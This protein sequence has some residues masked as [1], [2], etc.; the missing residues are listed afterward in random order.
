MDDNQSEPLILIVDDNPQNLQVLGKLLTESGY[1]LCIAQSGQEALE[2]VRTRMPDLIL[3]DVMMPEMDGYTVCQRL[4]E[5]QGFKHIPVIFLT[6]RTDTADIIKGFEVGGV[7]Y[8][9]KPFNSIELLA[10][11]KTHVEIKTLR[12]L[13]PLCS[14][15]KNVRD[16]A[17][18]WK[19]LEAYIENHTE[20]LF[21]HGV[22][23]DCMQELY[24]EQEWF[25]RKYD[26]KGTAPDT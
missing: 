17:G 6:A 2:Y 13:L 16:D 3:L 24:G 9:G 12:G 8:V 26:K 23:P 19:R 14:N 11:V 15:C 20:T 7:D 22:C 18:M 21:S 4:K 25:Q 5:Q 10:R 1:K